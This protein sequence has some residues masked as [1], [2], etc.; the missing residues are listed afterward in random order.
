VRLPVTPPVT[1]HAVLDALEAKYPR[2]RANI[3]DHVSQRR[4]ALVRFFA[5]KEGLSDEL[6]DAPLPD[7]VVNGQEPFLVS[8]AAAG[9]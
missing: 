7:T 6:P 1:Q 8:G 9:G 5:C 4:R 2:L 3:R